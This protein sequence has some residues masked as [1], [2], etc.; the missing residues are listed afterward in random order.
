MEKI[1]DLLGIAE[2]IVTPQKTVTV[3]PHIVRII[4]TMMILSIV[5]KICTM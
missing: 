3:I 4:L 2:P 1:N 5:E